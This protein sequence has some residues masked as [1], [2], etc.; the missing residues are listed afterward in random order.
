MRP[1]STRPAAIR[2]DDVVAGPAGVAR[3]ADRLLLGVQAP[4]GQEA[5][6]GVGLVE[7]A[8]VAG[9]GEDA[10]VGR[11]DHHRATEQT[12]EPRGHLRQAASFDHDLEQRRQR[13]GYR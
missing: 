8:D 1:W 12:D 10:P 3:Q 13:V 4:G 5:G 2:L 11:S 9:V 6:G 7:I